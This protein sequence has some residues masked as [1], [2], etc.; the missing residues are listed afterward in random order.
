MV[1]A[2]WRFCSDNVTRLPFAVSSPTALLPYLSKSIIE[3]EDINAVLNFNITQ[4]TLTILLSI[5]YTPPKLGTSRKLGCT[6][7]Q[8]YVSRFIVRVAKIYIFKIA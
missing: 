1:L 3:C 5:F 8:N 2:K 6:F 7:I 4:F